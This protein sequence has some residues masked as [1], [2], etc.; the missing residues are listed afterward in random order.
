MLYTALG[1]P[2]GKRVTDHCSVL[3][4]K[5]VGYSQELLLPRVE[6]K[7]QRNAEIGRISRVYTVHIEKYLQKTNCNFVSTEG[8]TREHGSTSR[9]FLFSVIHPVAEENE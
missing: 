1:F 3:V 4:P 9:K 6:R 8:I 2:I 5:S 7:W